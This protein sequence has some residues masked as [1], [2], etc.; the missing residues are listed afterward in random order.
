MA[1]K[2][3]VE[4]VG[5]WDSPYLSTKSGKLRV[6]LLEVPTQICLEATAFDPANDNGIGPMFTIWEGNWLKTKVVSTL[7]H[8]MNNRT[9]T[10]TVINTLDL[11]LVR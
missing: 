7:L 3:N 11:G 5:R 1:K 8:T 9:A 10:H 2:W 6:T 4:L